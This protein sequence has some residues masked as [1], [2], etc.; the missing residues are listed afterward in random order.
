MAEWDT[1]EQ[2]Q[3]DTCTL[4]STELTGGGSAWYV[5]SSCSHPGLK[6]QRE[7]LAGPFGAVVAAT[8]E[9]MDKGEWGRWEEVAKGACIPDTEA[10]GERPSG[11]TSAD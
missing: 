1:E 8:I 9:E 6:A 3:L 4:C 5:M 10:S 2:S 11:P 7:R